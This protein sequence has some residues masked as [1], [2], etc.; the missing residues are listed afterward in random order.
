[1]SSASMKEY[2]DA[3]S[4][5]RR[6]N[7]IG[8]TGAGKST[9]ATAI[10]EALRLPCVHL[11]ELSWDPNWVETPK[12][13]FEARLLPHLE[14]GEWVIDGNYRRIRELFKDD[15]EALVWIDYSFPRCFCQ[16]MRRTFRRWYRREVICN[17][18][19]EVFWKHFV[20]RDSLILWQIQTHGK[21]QKQYGAM[22]ASDELKHLVRVRVKSPKER[23]A[24]LEALRSG[25]TES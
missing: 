18:N 20:T 17:G 14:R 5:C 6:I 19:V 7:V 15:I 16:L 23:M 2:A 25:A 9:T 21:R 3:L 4:R 13:V 12:E 22:F 10:A 1:M 11:D 8:T 24:L